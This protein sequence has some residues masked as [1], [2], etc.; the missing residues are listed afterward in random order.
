[1]AIEYETKILNIEKKDIENKLISFG[2]KKL[3]EHKFRRWVL[4]MGNHEWT[5]L[6]DEGDKVTLTYKKRNNKEI[7]GVE[8]IETIVEDF[9]EIAEI[10]LKQKWVGTY[11]QEN[12]RIMYVMDNIEFCIDNWPDIPT[13]LEIEGKSM[14]DVKKGLKM[15]DLEKHDVG[16]IS[17]CDVYEKYDINLHD[18]DVLKFNK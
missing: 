9:D 7:D 2:A 17:V 15:L 8:E 18:R 4:D 13:Y 5:R 11:Y 14:E 16:N 6:R 1:M 3:F 12:K 10:L